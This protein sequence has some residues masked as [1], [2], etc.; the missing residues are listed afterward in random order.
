M[1][2]NIIR[3]LIFVIPFIL[4]VLTIS[5]LS[6]IYTAGAKSVCESIMD[7]DYTCE[8][9]MVATNYSLRKE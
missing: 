2:R 3:L 4:G 8:W 6:T 7:D 9:Q 1:Q 5:G